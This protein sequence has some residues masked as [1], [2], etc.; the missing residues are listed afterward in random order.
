MCNIC[1]IFSSAFLEVFLEETG[2]CIG[3]GAAELQPSPVEVAIAVSL[4]HAGE[5]ESLPASVGEV[6]LP[7]ADVP[8][9]AMAAKRDRC[10]GGS[11]PQEPQPSPGMFGWCVAAVHGPGREPVVFAQGGGREEW[12]PAPARLTV[13]RPVAQDLLLNSAPRGVLFIGRAYG[14]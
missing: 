2:L 11:V 12:A 3:H 10:H 9:H 8:Q 4:S 1:C 6:M 14:R 7:H 5:A 13:R